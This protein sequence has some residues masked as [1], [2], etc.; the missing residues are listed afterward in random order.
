VAGLIK[1]W[2]MMMVGVTLMNQKCEKCG[3]YDHELFVNNILI[4][5]KC[6]NRIYNPMLEVEID[7][8]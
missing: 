2:G 3:H 1:K 6:R 4:C 5:E 7:G 8:N